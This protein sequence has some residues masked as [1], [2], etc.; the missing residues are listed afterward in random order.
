MYK[1][2]A[3]P[4]RDLRNNYAELV[5]LVNDRNQVIITNNGREETVL[6]GIE[7]YREYEAYVH[8]KYVLAQ[9]A[10]SK[11]QAADPNTV[12]L[13]HEEVMGKFREKYGI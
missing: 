7:D 9:L 11:K 13:S 2:F 4:S 8:K 3:R 6:I 10:E 12:W 1:T 5:R